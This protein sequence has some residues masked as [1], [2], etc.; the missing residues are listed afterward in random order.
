[1]TVRDSGSTRSAEPAD[2][3]RPPQRLEAFL[4]MMSAERGAA[5]NT[6]QAYRRDLEDCFADHRRRGTRRSRRRA[7]I[8]A[9]LAEH[10]RAR[11]RAVVAGA[12]SCR[13]CGSS[14]SSSTP[15]GCA[16]TTRPA[17]STAPGRA[18][19]LP[20]SLSVGRSRPR[21]STAP[22]RKR[23]DATLAGASGCA[24]VRM[25]ALVEVL[26]ATGLRVSELV[27]CR[28]SVALR[29]ERF[30]VVRGKGDKERMVP[31]TEAAR[32]AMRAYLEQRSRDPGGRRQHVAVSRRRRERASDRARSSPATSRRLPARAGIARARSRR[33]CCATPSPAICCR[34]APICA[35]CSSC[36]ATPTSRRRRSTPMCSTSG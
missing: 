36:S 5:D 21:C 32:A 9:Y 17:R 31:L 26:Y 1:M 10:R 14:T 7:D 15:R 34:T 29:D 4:E 19:P 11:L 16:P 12:A 35:P 27:A 20:R 13:R 24:R 6:L 33:T 25:H 3:Q 23:R 8:R 30:L 22:P 28:V 18:A 2:E